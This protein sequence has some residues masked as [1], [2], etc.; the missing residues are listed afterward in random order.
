VRNQPQPC[1]I[2]QFITQTGSIPRGLAVGQ[3]ALDVIFYPAVF[4]RSVGFAPLNRRT[5]GQQ[6]ECASFFDF[7]QAKIERND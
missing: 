4:S 2:A 7:G 5:S 6:S 1:G 3:F